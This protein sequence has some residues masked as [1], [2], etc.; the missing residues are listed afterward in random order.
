MSNVINLFT[1]QPVEMPEIT[2]EEKVKREEYQRKAEQERLEREELEKIGRDWLEANQPA[3]V[4]AYIIAELEE[5]DCDSMTDYYG[6]HT[7][8]TV[9][10]AY[11]KHTRDLFSEM[12]KAADKFLETQHL[13]T[14]K[15]KYSIWEL[16]NPGDPYKL[17]HDHKYS[18]D[19]G[20][21]WWA[22]YEEA[23]AI[24]EKLQDEDEANRQKVKRNEIQSYCPNFPYGYKITGDTKTIEHRE[25]YSMGGGYYLGHSRYSG[26]KVSKTQ[27]MPNVYRAIAKGD[28]VLGNPTAAPQEP[29]KAGSVEIRHNTDQDGIE[30]I[31]TEKPDE[32]TRNTLKDLKFRWSKR[33]RLWYAKYTPQLMN[34]V[35]KL[36]QPELAEKEESDRI[37]KMI[38]NFPM[39]GANIE[40]MQPQQIETLYY[41]A[42][43]VVRLYEHEKTFYM[44]HEDG[45][46]TVLNK[47]HCLRF[48]DPPDQDNITVLWEK[49]TAENV[50]GETQETASVEEL[51]QTFESNTTEDRRSLPLQ[52]Q[53]PEKPIIYILNSDE[54]LSG[55]SEIVGCPVLDIFW[56]NEKRTKIACDTDKDIYI[57]PFKLPSIQTLIDR[58][59]LQEPAEPPQEETP[60]ES[61]PPKKNWLKEDQLK[62]FSKGHISFYKD[63]EYIRLENGTIA[64]AHRSNV[65]DL[66]TGIRHCREYC[67]P[68]AWES[69]PMRAT[70]ENEP[71]PEQNPLQT[72]LL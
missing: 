36:F 1:M 62:T 53:E 64:I 68:K 70:I 37:Q 34:R 55:I 20:I 44:L 56:S 69:H 28:H 48:V 23:Q 72:L 45:Q 40:G 52:N 5:S 32:A 58:I 71:E 15:G 49:E 19:T 22:T 30:I 16:G 39:S 35:K 26:W 65:I 33:N 11:S 54:F 4:K 24:A 27:Y 59:T 18:T 14:G 47:N 43:K 9:V 57:L 17:G 38:D 12:R 2:T 10:L 51:Q 61:E 67:C 63:H 25:K 42:K 46:T 6:S 50:Q 21:D 66:D 13:G 41:H 29:A 60:T 8:K 7:T 3:G 31:F